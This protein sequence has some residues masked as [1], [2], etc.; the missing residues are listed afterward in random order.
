MA[1]ELGNVLEKV[2]RDFDKLF[3]RIGTIWLNEGCDILRED[4]VRRNRVMIK[5]TSEASRFNI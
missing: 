5:R 4:V 3:P 1:G 2:L